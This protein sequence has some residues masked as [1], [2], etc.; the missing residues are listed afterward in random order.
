MPIS[1]RLSLSL[2]IMMTTSTKSPSSTKIPR[3]VLKAGLLMIALVFAASC[4]G[5]LSIEYPAT[6]FYGDNIL[7]KEKTAYTNRENS[8]QFKPSKDASAK[9]KITGKTVTPGTTGSIGIAGL[10]K[11]IW[12]IEATTV[13]NL[14]RS[15][16]DNS[17]YSQTFTSIDGGITCSVKLIFDKG[18]FEIEYFENGSETPTFSKTIT[19]D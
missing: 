9:I 5:D 18:T 10:T 7:F 17:T 16:F 14:V 2:K 11:G 12:L 6:G 8:L 1:P 15:T 4:D 19:V 3:A 13:N